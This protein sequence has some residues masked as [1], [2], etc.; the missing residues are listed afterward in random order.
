MG[1]FSSRGR[2]DG[3]G[4]GRS[5]GR[6]DSG[7]SETARENAA[8]TPAGTPAGSARPTQSWSTVP[9]TQTA[10]DSRPR[11]NDS[12]TGRSAG[13]QGGNQNMAAIGKSIVFKGELTGDE[14]L[15]IE[16]QVE[17]N[18]RLANHTLTIGANGRLTAQVV[19]KSIIVIGR[20]KGNLTATERIEIQ[21][22][23]I[24][25]GDVKAPRLNVQE[26]AVLNGG[27]DMSASA[28]SAAASTGQ[29]PQAPRDETRK[30][31]P[32]IT[33]QPAAPGARP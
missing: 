9:T 23:G 12:T 20:V 25:E 16:G 27:I 15:E 8:A 11:D 2:G 28:Q 22:T 19:A 6:G 29:A 24:V 32:P 10:S 14:D 31:A 33:A 17:G 21:A 18:V 4:E 1:F 3:R 7:S 5:E 30:P 26:G 13:A